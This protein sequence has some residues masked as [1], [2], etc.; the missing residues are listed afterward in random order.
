MCYAQAGA[1]RGGKCCV[2]L[3][4]CASQLF[5]PLLVSV[6]MRAELTYPSAEPGCPSYCGVLRSS[7]DMTGWGVWNY[8]ARRKAQVSLHSCCADGHDA[9]SD[10]YLRTHTQITCSIPRMLQLSGP[11]LRFRARRSLAMCYA[12]AGAMRGGKCCV[13]L[14]CWTAQLASDSKRQVHM[15]RAAKSREPAL[16]TTVRDLH[17]GKCVYPVPYRPKQSTYVLSTVT[18]SITS[19]QMAANQVLF[20]EIFGKSKNE[21]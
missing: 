14:G 12:Q 4:W 2:V 18:W 20:T 17:R 9:V 8:R 3:S 16:R 6:H 7:S 15:R 1:M 5:L 21:S 11:K 10:A 19:H 13:L